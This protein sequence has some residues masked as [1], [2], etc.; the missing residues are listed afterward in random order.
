MWQNSTE[1][2][3]GDDDVVKINGGNL[4]RAFQQAEV[5]STQMKTEMDSI[6]ALINYDFSSDPCRTPFVAS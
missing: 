3:I 6:E 2:D 4:L 1:E 5:V